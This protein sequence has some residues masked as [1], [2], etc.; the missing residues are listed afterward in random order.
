MSSIECRELSRKVLTSAT[1]LLC[2]NLNPKKVIRKLLSRGI[3]SDSDVQRINSE[4]A[5]D[6]SVD[7]LLSILKMKGSSAYD[8]FM[9]GLHN[10]DIHLHQQ[11]KQIEAKFLMEGKVIWI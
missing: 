2:E 11:V 4:K 6:D 8:C 7:A 1:E 10:V 3:L 5:N 9:N